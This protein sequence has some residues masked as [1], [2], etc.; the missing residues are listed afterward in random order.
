MGFQSVE[1]TVK[2]ARGS[3][4]AFTIISVA[5]KLTRPLRT[6]EVKNRNEDLGIA[7]R[8]LSSLEPYG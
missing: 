2:G 6:I 8:Y 4:M 3:V 5:G 7:K 1:D